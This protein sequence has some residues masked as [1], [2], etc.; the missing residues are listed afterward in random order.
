MARKPSTRPASPAGAAPHS[1][2]GQQPVG[3]VLPPLPRQR[4][5][6]MLLLAVALVVIGA[7]LAGYLFTG[8]SDRVSVVVVTRNVPVGQQLTA[9][10]VST[11]MV[12]ADTTVA[13][14]PGRQRDQV[15]GR[16]A[17]VDLRAGTLLAPS[18]LTTALSPRPGQQV[19]PVAVTSRQLPARGLRPGDQVLVIATP[20]SVS[21]GQ[22]EATGGNQA[23]ALTQDTA[24][25]VD[26]VSAPD[27]EGAVRVDLVVDA[28]VGSAIAKQ[29]STGRIAFVLTA[30][31]TR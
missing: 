2:D 29:A 17:A 3:G 20:G 19:V 14:I 13:Q 5:R 15:V 6:R 11:T 7:A 24:A 30:R 25:T 8:M 22:S 18:Q 21:A 12:A 9:A 27:A 4:R 1:P 23:A 31:G 10:D 16:M 28:R 26:Q